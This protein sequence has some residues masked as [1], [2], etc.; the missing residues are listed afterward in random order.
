MEHMEV[1]H[2]NLNLG[3]NICTWQQVWDHP[4][5]LFQAVWEKF[6]GLEEIYFCEE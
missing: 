3:S 4:H 2:K 1:I 6:Q 5:D